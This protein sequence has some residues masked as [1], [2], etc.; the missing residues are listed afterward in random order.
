VV[1][2]ST[3][4]QTDPF[5][6]GYT[7]SSG[8]NVYFDIRNKPADLPKKLVKRL[9]KVYSLRVA[10]GAPV[11]I[12][13]VEDEEP[14][15]VINIEQIYNLFVES[16]DDM[17]VDMPEESDVEGS[18]QGSEEEEEE[19]EIEEGEEGE[20]EVESETSERLESGNEEMKN[21]IRLLLRQKMV[22]MIR[23]QLTV[24]REE[25]NLS[26]L[27]KAIVDKM[28][29]SNSANIEKTI[30]EIIE[31]YEADNE[32]D[33]LL[34][35]NIKTSWVLEYLKPNIPD[36][37]EVESEGEE[38]EEENPKKVIRRDESKEEPKPSRGI[39]TSSEGEE[40]KGSESERSDSPSRSCKCV[41]CGKETSQNLKT[42][43]K[44]GNEF[45]T[46]CFC[47][48]KCFEKFKK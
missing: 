16:L 1:I 19:S 15:E 45:K 43:I 6:F 32:L 28:V 41:K 29:N 21:E 38:E 22:D 40:E 8:E 36:I 11:A 44:D 48:F 9:S 3:V 20:S 18:S 34:N 27:G 31:E 24:G 26:P 25:R 17:G 4:D 46:V 30:T 7:N 37:F 2:V 13:G 10:G 39:F 12:E 42:K 5:V 47:S 33:V 35:P 14:D 23:R